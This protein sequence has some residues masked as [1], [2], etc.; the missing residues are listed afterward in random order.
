MIAGG[1]GVG[2]IG[3]RA[4]AIPP[5]SESALPL[6]HVVLIDYRADVTSEEAAAIA[7]D[8]RTSLRDLPGILSLELGTQARSDRDVHVRDYD[9]AMHIKFA[10]ASDLDLYGPHPQ[11]QAFLDRHRDR[12]ERIQV[13]DF[14]GE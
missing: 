6:H 7:A 5:A 13:I 8:A 4:V 11:H 2:G 9:W 1:I 10:Q 14:Y 12:W 3:G